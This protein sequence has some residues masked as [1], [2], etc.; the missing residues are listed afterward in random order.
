[1]KRF[2]LVLLVSTFLLAPAAF[3]ACSGGGEGADAGRTAADTLTRRQKDSIISTMPIPGA[4]AV[5]RAL[6]AADSAQARADRHDSLAG[7]RR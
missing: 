1:M 6:R 4:G 7:V 2:Q 3:A 5:G